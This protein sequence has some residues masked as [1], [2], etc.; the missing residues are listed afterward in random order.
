MKKFDSNPLLNLLHALENKL[1][2]S[3]I[4]SLDIGRKYQYVSGG[5]LFSRNFIFE[6]MEDNFNHY[7]I[8]IEDEFTIPLDKDF[9]L[10]DAVNQGNILKIY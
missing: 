10:V 2:S 1:E 4:Q 3:P 6:V 9:L 5:E 8:L 7:I